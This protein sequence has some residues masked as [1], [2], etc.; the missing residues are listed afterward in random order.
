MV[1][2][3]GDSSTAG[4]SSAC[5]NGGSEENECSHGKSV[6]TAE[7]GF[8]PWYNPYTM[9]INRGRNCYNC[10][11]FEHITRYC[12]EYKNQRRIG[13]KRR[14]NYEDNRNTS[15]LNREENLMVLD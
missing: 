9:N 8:V 4:T 11:G 14:M 3:V 1:E 2:D 13:W 5:S 7:I 12:R 15:N 10:G 6:I